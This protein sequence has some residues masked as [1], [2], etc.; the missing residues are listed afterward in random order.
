MVVDRNNMI[1]NQKGEYAGSAATRLHGSDDL[2]TEEK[3]EKEWIPYAD[4]KHY[5]DHRLLGA[6]EGE[7]VDDTP[8]DPTTV[9]GFREMERIQRNAKHHV[10]GLIQGW[11]DGGGE[12]EAE[13]LISLTTRQAM[14]VCSADPKRCFSAAYLTYALRHPRVENWVKHKC[15]INVS[16]LRVGRKYQRALDRWEADHGG[17]K[18]NGVEKDAIWDKTAIDLFALKRRTTKSYPRVEVALSTGRS[19]D[20]E[21]AAR[22][23]NKRTYYITNEVVKKDKDGKEVTDK[24]GRPIMVKVREK[25]QVTMNGRRYYELA[26]IHS[27]YK[28]R[29][30]SVDDEIDKGRL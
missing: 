20:P 18:P 27:D 25:R 1:H 16:Y 9:D 30:V 6:T 22:N 28:R 15:G 14:W 13:E 17:R 3:E 21:R 7:Y 24:K 5:P 11:I 4:R 23:G 19:S 2:E 12:S 26:L 29:M 10:I 8:L